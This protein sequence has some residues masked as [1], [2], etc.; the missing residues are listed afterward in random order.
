MSHFGHIFEHTHVC[1]QVKCHFQQF[2]PYHDSVWFDR[3]LNT[4]FYSAASLKYH[5]PD[6]WHDTISSHIILTL[7]QPVLALTHQ[8]EF[9]ARSS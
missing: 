9:Q 8:S 6:T 7:G 4:H 5:V 2:L 1:I 3:E